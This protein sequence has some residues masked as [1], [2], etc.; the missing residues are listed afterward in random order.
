MAWE[1][2]AEIDR[3]RGRKGREERK[4][5]I[6]QRRRRRRGGGGKDAGKSQI[7]PGAVDKIFLN[8]KK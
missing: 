1:G 6:H 3:N 8:W 5:Q 2:D 7:I 4:S